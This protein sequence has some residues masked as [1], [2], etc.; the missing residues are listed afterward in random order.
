MH[1]IK[2]LHETVGG[3]KKE[4]RT[5]LD[6]DTRKAVVDKENDA[7]LKQLEARF[8]D[9]Q[10]ALDA[11]LRQK[12]REDQNTSRFEQLSEGEQRDVEAFDWAK[13]LRDLAAGRQQTGIELELCTEGEEEARQARV[14]GSGGI[15]LPSFFAQR[16]AVG[17]GHREMRDSKGRRIERRDMTAT[18][19]TNLNQGG[20]VIATEKM[21]VL[22]AL[23]NA[24]VLRE[25]GAQVLTGLTGNFDWPR[26]TMGTPAAHKGENVDGA[27]QSPTVSGAS[28][29][30]HRLPGYIELSDQL[31]LQSGQVIEAI[32]NRN[33]NEQVTSQIEGFAIEG[34]GSNDQPVGIL[35]TTGIG[36]V[37]G[38]TNGAAP[39][40]TDIVNLEAKVNIANANR[41]TLHYLTN[42]KV[43]AMLNTT[44][45]VASTD[46]R[47]ILEDSASAMLNG[48]K[49]LF[50]NNVAATRTKGSAS[51]VCSS[52]IF[53]QF[54]DLVIGF[55]SGIN[56]EMVRDFSQAK[57]GKRA[58]VFNVYGDSN[59]IRPASFSA[60]KDAL[61]TAFN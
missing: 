14:G 44:P 49:P 9:A 39:D 29:S 37:A 20:Y 18:G 2:Q 26:L 1:K 8:N 27:E 40:W 19:G 46:S 4:I 31:L 3:L 52:I 33:V 21:G 59:V 58:L 16:R 56:L 61:T 51:G 34:T 12:A 35:S 50:T 5:Y 55:W 48:Y 32:V 23:F 43:K 11:E 10:A 53:G 45:K 24:L 28:F 57:A 38:G 6:S 47:M 54:S 13:C 42:Y 7:H 15:Y 60:M 30:P 17:G 36:A 41:G 25:A 22:D